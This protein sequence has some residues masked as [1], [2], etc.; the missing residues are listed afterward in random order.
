MEIQLTAKQLKVTPALRDYVQQKMGKAQK[1]FDHIVWGQAFLFVEKR[2]HKA[3]MIVHAP[4]QTF[5]ALATA[6]DLYSAIDLASDKIDAQLKKHKER[7]KTR[8]KA[9]TSE[10]MSEAV[11][12]TSTTFS[13][14]RQPVE[15]TAPER[16]VEEMEAA[17]QQFLVYLDKDT[18]QIHVV[19]RRG[20]ETFGIIQPVR[21]SKR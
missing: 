18:D 21:K 1:Y 5:R 19:F 15:A 13:V 4:G 9:K 3:E 16:A 7:V 17:G 20:D 11:P 8:H 2:A 6:A 10:T 12:P 14:V